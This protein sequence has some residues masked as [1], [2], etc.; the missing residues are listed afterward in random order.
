MKT[1]DKSIDTSVLDRLLNP[2][3]QRMTPAMARRIVTFRADAETRTRVQELADKCS[4][5]EL[6]QAESREYKAYV[7]AVH[8]VSVLQSKARIVLRKHRKLR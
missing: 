7:R 5:G 6:S 3:S 8:L 2:L 1:L 4:E